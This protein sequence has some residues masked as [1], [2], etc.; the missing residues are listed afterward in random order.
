MSKFIQ[1]LFTINS[2]EKANKITKK[3]LEKRAASCVQIIGPTISS[4]WW[5]N[6]I[7]QAIEWVCLA[8]SKAENFE[9]IESIIKSLHPFKVP[10]IIAIP[11]STGNRDYLRWIQEETTH[12][13]Q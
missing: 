6:K 9:K 8:K 1:I 5:E 13:T 2:E 7:Q 3:L 12:R 4:Y 10:D 11:I